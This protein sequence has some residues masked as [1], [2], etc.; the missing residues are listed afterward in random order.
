MS[1]GF[2][3]TIVIVAA[4]FLLRGFLRSRRA[5]ET[6]LPDSGSAI[7][8][9]GAAFPDEA[10]RAAVHTRDGTCTFLRLA[11]GK[12]GFVREGARRDVARVIAR[13]EVTMTPLDDPKS[14]GITFQGEGD[15]CETFVF[16]TPQDAAE[17]A[18][19]LLGSLVEASGSQPV[20]NK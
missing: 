16:A 3:V 6:D 4:L 17:V 19:W 10:V 11:D 1:F 12:T 8:A 15:G 14:L 13:G 9:F 2:V 20:E 5:A 18:L 7:L